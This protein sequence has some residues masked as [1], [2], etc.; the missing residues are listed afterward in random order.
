MDR[1]GIIV[2]TLCVVLLGLWFIEQQKNY[3]HPPPQPVANTTTTTT[4]AAHTVTAN[5]N[6][7]APP[8][9]RVPVPVFDPNTPE[10]LLV[11]T[12]ARPRYT[13]PS[14]G[15]RLKSVELL[16]YPET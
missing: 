14:R 2:V 11:I 13:F 6:A 10:E 15:G 16:D 7:V 12:N 1:T 3:P 9:N 5:S 4:A 8:P